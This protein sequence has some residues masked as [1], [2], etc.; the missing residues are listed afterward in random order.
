[1]TNEKSFIITKWNKI[2][3]EDNFKTEKVDTENFP[4]KFRVCD[5]DDIPYFYGYSN[6][7]LGVRINVIKSKKITFDWCFLKHNI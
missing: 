3:E 7:I 5:D 6:D 2:F 1:M 4:Y